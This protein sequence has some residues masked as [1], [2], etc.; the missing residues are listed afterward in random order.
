MIRQINH[1]CHEFVNA[2]FGQLTKEVIIRLSGQP[3]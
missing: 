1:R 3:F 2:E